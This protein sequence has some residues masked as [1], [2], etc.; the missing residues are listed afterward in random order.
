MG[1]EKKKESGVNN[2]NDFRPLLPYL[3]RYR[4]KLAWGFV[5]VVFYILFF[6]LLPYFVGNAIDALKDHP[7][8]S[9]LFKYFCVSIGT[10]LIGSVFLFFTRRTIIVASREI[11]NDLRHD[12]F[13]HIENHPRTFYNTNT[14]G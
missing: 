7:D 6:T 10:V 8:N 14:T 13:E 9:V 11:E 1:I 3:K 5:C 4:A 12:F 2:M